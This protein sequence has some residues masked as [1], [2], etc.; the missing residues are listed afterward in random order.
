MKEAPPVLSCTQQRQKRTKVL[1]EAPVDLPLHSQDAAGKDA[2][3]GA[4]LES[5]ALLRERP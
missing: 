2:T 1:H 4:A 3:H 5:G